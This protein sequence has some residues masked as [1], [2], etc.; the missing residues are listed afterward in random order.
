[1]FSADFSKNLEHYESVG[2]LELGLSETELKKR[3]GKFGISQLFYPLIDRYYKSVEDLVKPGMHVL[4]IG[5]GTGY[6]SGIVVS[7]EA[8]LTGVDISKE[9]LRVC[10]KKHP[11]FYRLIQANMEEIPLPAS[12]FDV[13]V[14]FGSLSYGNPKKVQK[15]IF[16]LLK[17]G[18]HLIVKDT[19]NHNLIFRFN[20]WI[21]YKKGTRSRSTLIFMPRLNFINS[22]KDNFNKSELYFYGSYLWI[23]YPISKFLGSYYATRSNNLAER[24]FPSQKNAFGFVMTCRGYKGF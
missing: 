24:I 23:F 4:E 3:Q 16:R 11:N 7:Q 6:H 10:A 22:F 8:C 19:L 9:C 2:L 17:N 12:S 15:E 18:G 1:M 13:I 20:R 21:E 14:I 5:C